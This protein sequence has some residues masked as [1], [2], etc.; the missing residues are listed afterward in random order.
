VSAGPPAQREARDGSDARAEARSDADAVVARYARREVGDL[1]SPLRP[2]VML[3]LQERQRALLRLFS[4]VGI[5]DPAQIDALEVGCGSGGNLLELLRLGFA[6]ERLSGIE[7]LPERHAQARRVLPAATRL[8]LG[9]ATDATDAAGQTLAPASQHIVLQATVFSSLLEPAAEQ[10]L[11]G[12]MWCW[13]RPGG[14]VLWYDLAYDN[15]RNADVQGLPL[16]RVRALFPQGELM[17]AERVTLV[18][19]LARALCR[20]HPALYGVFN[21]LPLLRS[22]WLVWI[23]KPGGVLPGRSA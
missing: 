6:P 22:H 11:A 4:R 21:A 13:L 19:P 18:P 5:V 16:A 23:G 20:V 9:D 2:E 14:G 1:Y 10:R 8:W 15:P 3:L 17:F 12:A 7:L